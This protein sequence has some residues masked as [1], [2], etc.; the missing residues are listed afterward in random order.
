VKKIA[1][2][3]DLLMLP[4]ILENRLRAALA[5]LPGEE[6]EIRTLQQP[7][8]DQPMEHGYA[9]E[10]MDGL[11]EYMGTADEIVQFVADAEILIT[12]LAPMSKSMF[13]RLPALKFIAVTRGGPVNIDMQAAAN[14]GVTVVNTPGRN[15]S[16]VA[17]FTLGAM[18]AESRLIRMGH[19]SMREGQWR[20]D[21]YRT[22]RTGRELNEICVGVIGYGHIGKRV[23]RLLRAFGSR[24]LVNDPYVQ[25]STQDLDDGVELVCFDSL[26]RQSDVVTLHARVTSETEHMMNAEAFE[27]MIK[28]ITNPLLAFSIVLGITL[29]SCSSEGIDRNLEAHNELLLGDAPSAGNAPTLGSPLDRPG[30]NRYVL[31]EKLNFEA[32]L[33]SI[34]SILFR[35]SDQYGNAIS[36][37]QTADFSLLEDNQSVSRAETSLSVVP[38]QELPFSLMTVIMIDVSSS[39]QPADLDKTKAAVNSLLIDEN[40]SSRLLP[41]QQVALYTFDDSVSQLKGFSSNADSLVAT[42]NAIQPAIAITPTDFYGAVIEGT[43]QWTDSFDLSSIVQGTLIIITDGTDT[44][45]RHSYKEALA[46]S[47]GKAVYTLGVGNEIAASTLA[48]VGTAG[49]YA[50]QNFEQLQQALESIS[51]QV[52]NTANSFYYL[53][54]ASPKRRAEG[55]GSSNHTIKLSVANNAN[56]SASG[57]I[58]ENFN[59]ADFSNV[60]AQLVVSGPSRIET[61]QTAT[62]RASTRWGPSPDTSYVWTIDDRNEACSMDVVSNSAARVTGVAEGSCTIQVEDLSAGSVRTWHSISVVSD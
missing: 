37:L 3:G 2:V 7:W 49:S 8:P 22:D 18:L 20:G 11:K 54:Y 42:I 38:Q 17:E 4:E 16:A 33:P 52:K 55:A 40:G 53:H 21:L 45:G 61:R 32:A 50:L 6:F 44:A 39:I 25:L 36:G 27:K 24:V 43:A 48:S 12:H 1:I 15:A 34:I 31:L 46:A 9:V 56:S 35:A 28:K 23:V 26:L 19:E 59:S 10:G 29:S 13:E 30:P 5:D 41:Q 14:Q 47:K 60:S 58:T 62:L 57:V 51:Q